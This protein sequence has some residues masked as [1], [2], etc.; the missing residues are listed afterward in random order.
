MKTAKARGQRLDAES[1]LTFS[2]S[3]GAFTALCFI[4][5]WLMETLFAHD[6]DLEIGGD[7]DPH[8]A[9]VTAHLKVRA[10]CVH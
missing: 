3:R 10:W 9:S 7:A 6:Q 4:K 1:Q 5:V 2:W 8:P